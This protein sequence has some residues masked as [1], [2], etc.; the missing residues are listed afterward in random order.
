MMVDTW[1]GPTKPSIG[2]VPMSRTSGDS[3]MCEI[4]EGVRTWLQKTRK[5]PR[6]LAS[7]CLIASAVGGVV[8]SKPIAN[9]TTSRSGFSS[10]SRSA[11]WVE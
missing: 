5:L 8:V 6:P 7:A 9:I 2:T 3:R 4:A 11:S 10:A 1:A